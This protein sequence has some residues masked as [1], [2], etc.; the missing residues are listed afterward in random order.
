LVGGVIA[1]KNWKGK[2]KTGKER[3]GV[4]ARGGEGGR[5]LRGR[6][7][8]QMGD[9]EGKGGWGGWG[10]PDHVRHF[11][12]KIGGLGVAP[13]KT[14]GGSGNT[15]DGKKHKKERGVARG[16]GGC[17]GTLSRGRVAR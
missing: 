11:A 1:L 6:K 3:R 17:A 16:E 13:I 2:K 9:D 12:R 14:F 5:G 8:F 15:R 10:Y 4:E 7:V